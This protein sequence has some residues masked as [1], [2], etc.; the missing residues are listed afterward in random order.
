MSAGP[1]TGQRGR[2]VADAS[3]EAAVRAVGLAAGYRDR[4]V[5][6]GLDVGIEPGSVTA[7]VGPNGS[8]KSTLLRALSRLLV[9]SAGTVQLEGKDIAGYPSAEVARRLAI[10][11]QR[12]TAPLTLTVA[13]LVEQGR[14]PH[15]GALRMLR[16]QDHQAIDRAIALTGMEGFVSRRLAELSGGEQQRAWI[17]LAL[18]QATPT[19]LLDEP[20]TFLDVGHQLEIM[21]LVARLNRDEELTVVL[22]LHDLNQAARYASRMLV[23][24]HGCIVADGAPAEVLTRELLAEVFRVAV[25]I[26]EDPASGAPVCIPYAP[27]GTATQQGSA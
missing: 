2:V 21:E 18:A 23:L 25:N 22:V 10:L 11:P 17:A 4:T 16:R 24:S 7:L 20:T 6:E 1:M 12:P 5:L 9:P 26:V 19:L 13:E 15:A 8:G 14:F 3:G 27:A